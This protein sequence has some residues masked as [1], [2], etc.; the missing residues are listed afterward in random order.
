MDL[1]KLGIIVLNYQTSDETIHFLES[2]YKFYGDLRIVV[3][4]NGSSQENKGKLLNSLIKK[5][6]SFLYL[7]NN[8]G[9]ARGLNAGIQQLRSEGYLFIACSNNDIL[10]LDDLSLHVL[11]ES[12]SD[13][14]VAISGPRILTPKGRN[15]NPMLSDRPNR[16]RAQHMLNYYSYPNIV[17]RLLF[18]RFILNPIKR[19]IRKNKKTYGTTTQ[20]T[21][22]NRYVYALNGAF[23]ILGPRFF[24]YYNELDPHT[25]LYAEELILAEMAYKIDLKMLY[26]PNAQLFHKEDQTS[27]AIWGGEDRLRPSFIARESMQHWYYHHYLKT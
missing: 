26:V 15:Q 22:N 27:N 7:E 11:A 8:L 18:N 1:H 2:A 13:E 20:F 12:L 17:S 3:I 24:E 4:D 5:N 10:F 14:S 16:S 6:T 9:Y 25:F 21:Q 23:F 19:Q